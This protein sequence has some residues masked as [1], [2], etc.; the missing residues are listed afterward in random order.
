MPWRPLTRIAFA[1]CT[2]PFPPSSPADL[3]LQVGD[4]LYIIEQGGQ[5]SAWYRGYLVAPPSLLAGLT[6]I[7]GRALEARVFSGIFPRDCVEI[8]E[9]LGDITA[10]GLGQP[11]NNEGMIAA[12]DK[13]TSQSISPS[14]IQE[15]VSTPSNPPRSQPSPTIA[16]ATSP[17]AAADESATLQTVRDAVACASTERHGYQGHRDPQS[18]PRDRASRSLVLRR[19]Y[20][21]HR[22]STT[23]HVRTAGSAK[24]PAPVPLL[25]IGDES[26][27]SKDEPLVDEIASCLREWHS[28]NLHELLL[29]RRYGLI[30]EMSELVTR[31]DFVRR[32]LLHKILTKHELGALRESAVWDLVNGN[33]A[34]ESDVI[35][36]SS[37]LKGRILTSDDSAI[38]ISRLQAIMSLL[39]EPPTPHI[40]SRALYH[41]LVEFKHLEMDGEKPTT[42]NIALYNKPLHGRPKLLSEVYSIEG[43]DFISGD[44]IHKTV[45]TE[46]SAADVGDVSNEKSKICLVVKVVTSE[47]VR[48][49][50]P[51]PLERSM[52][53]ERLSDVGDSVNG[54][55]RRPDSK[56]S[57]RQSLIWGNKTRKKSDVM[58]KPSNSSLSLGVDH[59]VEMA[60]GI[61]QFKEQKPVKKVTGI[62]SIDISVLMKTQD[63]VE[64]QMPVRSPSN[65]KLFA[66]EADRG[67]DDF[68]RELSASYGD[69]IPAVS[70]VRSITVQLKGFKHVDSDKLMQATPTLL[71]NIQQTQRIGFSGAPTK[72]RNDIYFTFNQASLSHHA[73]LAHPRSGNIPLPASVTMENLQLTMEVRNGAGD[74]IDECIFPSSSATGHTA[75]RTIAADKG[76]FWNQTIRLAVPRDEVPGSHV[77]MSLAN[78]YG[79]PFAL[80]WIP[81]W[82]QD[83]F[84]QDGDHKLLLYAYDETTSSIIGGKGAYLS[85]QWSPNS[86]DEAV[87]GL[88]A[89]LQIST[90]L[91]STSF[92]QDP[93][94]LGLLK[95]RHRS[96]SEIVTLLKRFTFVPEIESVKLLRQVF[97][98]LFGILVV[99][100]GLEELE[101]LNFNALVIILGIVHDRRFDL[102]PLV[103]EYTKTDFHYPSVFPCL[104]RS[105]ARLLKN[106][107]DQE[108]S[109][110]LRATSKVGGH[111]LKF[112][113]A[114]RQ[115]QIAKE[116]GIGLSGDETS[117]AANLSQIFAA[118]QDLMRNSTPELIGTKTLVV[119]NF[120]TW[121]PELMDVLRPND[122][123]SHATAFVDA[124]T[125]VH[126]KL[127][128]Y[129]LVLINN[130]SKFEIFHDHEIR[131]KWSESLVK[132]LAPYWG[133]PHSAQAPQQQREQIRLC[134]A[135][136]ATQVNER[137]P[138]GHKWIA[139][140]VQSFKIIQSLPHDHKDS[141]SLPFP[142]TYPFPSRPTTSKTTCNEALVE[143][144]ALLAVFSFDAR[145]YPYHLTKEEFG[146]FLEH[147]LHVFTSILACEAFPASWLSL[148][149]F[150]HKSVLRA[151]DVIQ[152]LMSDLFLPHP[153]DAEGFNT[154]LWR[155]FLT[156]LLNLI[157]SD[158]LALETFPEQKRRAVW[159]IGGD[160]REL[161]AKLL[162]RSWHALGWEASTQDQAYYGLHSM[163]G[164][165]VQYVPGLVGPIIE[166]CLSVHDGLRNAA[167]R[168][169]KTMIVNE[170]ALTQN[171]AVIQAEAIECL[172]GSFKRSGSH[173]GVL[174]K[175]FVAELISLFEPTKQSA[176]DPFFTAVQEFINTIDELLE[177][178]ADV[179]STNTGG[180]TFRILDTLRLMAFLR[181][182]QKEKIY[183]GYVHK[184]AKIQA[185]SGH[186]VEA[187]LALRMHVELYEWNPTTNVIELDDPPFPAQTSFERK[188]QIYLQMIHFFEVGLAW[189]HALRAYTELAVRYENVT[190]DFVKLA[191]VQRAMANVYERIANGERRNPRYFRVVYRGLGFPSSLRDKQFIFEASTM[192]RLGTFTDTLQQ[193]YPSAKITNDGST[194]ELE[195]QHLSVFPVNAQKQLL[196][197]VNRRP[198]ISQVIRDY[199]ML[200]ETNQFTIT[201]RR[202]A[203]GVGLAEHMQEKIVFITADAFPTVLQRSEIVTIETIRLSPIELG[204]ERTVRKT[205][206]LVALERHVRDGVESSLSSLTEGLKILVDPHSGGSVAGYWEL[207]HPSY[208]DRSAIVD[209]TIEL[210]FE[211]AQEALRI[212]LFDHA[213]AIARSLESYNKPILMPVRT[214]LTRGKRDLI[215]VLRSEY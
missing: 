60:N 67:W 163:S 29:N 41:L 164:Y 185:D 115:Q 3:P 122:I 201:S 145:N 151:L 107:M 181:D 158:A 191:Q 100:A 131:S 14:S 13:T 40:E 117:Y 88:P 137:R 183:I 15:K 104:V 92:S 99:Y 147:L 170:W 154:E 38:D 61:T 168:V 101:D 119:Q 19:A 214:E 146:I 109:R 129:K 30:H 209:P 177:L 141:L 2:Y 62:G 173:D 160:I 86:T 35:V 52:S 182:M 94:L 97:D 21:D 28:T 132:W 54:I 210:H 17:A 77:I 63:T 194:D 80:A 95:W 39:H 206:E 130:I 111:V 149:I 78:G 187:A 166:L 45:F 162:Q 9:L 49:V 167:I 105:F 20:A 114:A 33:K 208:A 215:A 18:T 156:T 102:E 11:T 112:I 157:G 69:H 106:P 211:P 58:L 152:V 125:D 110:Q 82:T 139:E 25:K 53:R 205:S 153:D 175:F 136:V 4:E 148:H 23:Q 50:K 32:Q 174:Q 120:H 64:W 7:K 70:G 84:L 34:L 190:F 184:L 42:I 200:A 197:P 57:G 213:T 207:I 134:C 180:E 161:G 46:L 85:L 47:P 43:A 72:P 75:W 26:A 202:Q 27:T 90:Y 186:P 150:Q 172:D 59:Q 103:E 96:S 65:H 1:I 155:L 55:G 169:L 76:E 126:G 203:T 138:E 5:D 16:S 133:N 87:I 165:Q 91:C 127:I 108:T 22:T 195:G 81:L 71:Q 73:V 56:Q 193:Q 192:A 159:K 93:N 140:L 171:L 48:V 36:R 10:Q 198:G 179:H 6:S 98:A 199:F 83:A 143:L 79:F 204:L 196:H 37:A 142:A 144:A 44:C 24:P 128:L 12:V 135:I 123:L 31:L 189:H 212:A 89:T 176:E 124:C 8:R 66:S 51:A 178:L 188:E 68:V 118:A 121:L 113:V 74:R 116:V